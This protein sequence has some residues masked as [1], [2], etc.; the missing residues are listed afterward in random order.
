MVTFVE[1]R[2]RMP[3]SCQPKI[4]IFGKRIAEKGRKDRFPIIVPSNFLPPILA[5]QRKITRKRSKWTIIWQH[6]LK[7]KFFILIHLFHCKRKALAKVTSIFNRYLPLFKCHKLKSVTSQVLFCRPYAI[8]VH[9]MQD[10]N[11]PKWSIGRGWGWPLPP[12]RFL[13]LPWLDLI[14]LIGL[15]YSIL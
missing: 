11:G 14:A 10:C 2:K 8:C 6:Y 13:V 1:N 15:A 12:K 7:F 5:K 9:S 3:M 4:R